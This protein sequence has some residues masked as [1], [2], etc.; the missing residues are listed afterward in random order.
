MAALYSALFSWLALLDAGLVAI[1]AIPILI[2]VVYFVFAGD[3]RPIPRGLKSAHGV[4]LVLALGYALFAFELGSDVS[5]VVRRGPFLAL[6]ALSFASMVYSLWNKR[7][8]YLYF[9]HVFTISY[10]LIVMYRSG[11]GAA[12]LTESDCWLPEVV[13]SVPVETPV[14]TGDKNDH[15]RDSCP[16]PL[17]R[18][19]SAVRPYGSLQLEVWGSPH[20]LY[21]K[22]TA[23]DGTHLQFS[24]DD[25]V[26]YRPDSESWLKQYSHFRRFPGEDYLD[27]RENTAFSVA[28]QDASGAELEQ[29]SLTYRTQQCRCRT[30]SSDF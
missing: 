20:V 1:I 7:R 23:S 30:S 13:V 25:V 27:T 22:G 4:L 10:A 24:G 21:M 15:R 28:V 16:V 2:S 12:T 3:R 11:M 17:P 9:L 14:L 29:L 19:M 18:V 8:W 26:G 6:M 5:L